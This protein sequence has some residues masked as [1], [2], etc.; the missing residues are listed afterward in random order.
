MKKVDKFKEPWPY[1]V[2]GIGLGIINIIMLYTTDEALKVSSWVA[3][4][5]GHIASEM[6][7]N[8]TEWHFF[9]ETV[10]P[11]GNATHLWVNTYTFLI[12]GIIVGAIM[13]ACM[14]SQWRIRKFKKIHITYA[15][16]GG[17]LMG[18]GTRLAGG[19]N[20]GAFFSAIPSFS[21]HGWIFGVSLFGGV[22]IGMKIL[23]KY[24]I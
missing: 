9:N 5:I 18:I 7:M 13:G 17:I 12:P 15:L 20:L 4:Q 11:V 1:W 21:L 2:A 14:S 6:G 16:V 23:K 8:A 10:E 24:R 19:C 22:Y 3:Y